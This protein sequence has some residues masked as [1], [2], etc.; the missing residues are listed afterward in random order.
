MS[1]QRPAVAGRFVL[2]GANPTIDRVRIFYLVHDL[3]DAAVARRVAMLRE[4][5]AEVTVAGFCRA[6]IAPA[7]IAGARAYNLGRSVQG[8]LGRRAML[9]LWRALSLGAWSAAARNADLILARNLECVVIGAALQRRRARHAAL[10]YELLDVHRTLLGS[11]QASQILRAVNDRLLRRCAAVIVSSPA[12]EREYLDRFHP[13]HAP[14]LLWENR[15]YGV[16]PETA[17]S[18]HQGPPWRIGWFGAIRCRKSLQTLAAVVR[19]NP[20][21]LEVDIRGRLADTDLGDVDAILRETPGLRYLGP[22]RYPHDLP[23]IYG[24]VHFTWAID[25]FEA[26]LNSNW[27][28]PNRLYEGGAMGVVPIALDGVETARWIQSR[29]IGVTLHGDLDEALE[30]MLRAMTVDRYEALRGALAATPRSDF[31]AC[32]DDAAS[33]L[34]ALASTCRPVQ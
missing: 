26:G 23:E 30:R 24:R 15:V 16:N 32:P 8:R 19:N 18:S 6:D 7:W 13:G 33:M 12:F 5:G 3:V 21:L 34:A 31:V 4:A 2:L 25:F 9:S 28:L 20:G 10:V 17:P 29:G 14:A 11:G 27:L 22:Y 1:P